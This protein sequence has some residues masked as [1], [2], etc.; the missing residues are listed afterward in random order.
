M[1][2][3]L[4]T[5]LAVIV[6]G[7]AYRES[8]R[9]RKSSGF[10]ALFSQ[11]IA[12]HKEAFVKKQFFIDFRKSFERDKNSIQTIDGLCDYW[13]RYQESLKNESVEFSHAFKYVY[14]EVV[15]VL[16]NESIDEQAKRHYIG[17]IQ[18][19]MNKDELL[20]Y[21][22]NLMQHFHRYPFD[23]NDIREELRHH[24]FFDDLTRLHD[25]RYRPLMECLDKYLYSDISKLVSF[26]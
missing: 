23:A 18:A 6:A 17:I 25:K 16:Y 13:D 3:A 2:Q 8:M 14:H 20:C 22:V 26:E 12:I 1:I 5:L 4:A 19:M 9:M 24:H 7:L 15:T 21:L 10:N 11:L